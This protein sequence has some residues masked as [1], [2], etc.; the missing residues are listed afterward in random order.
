MPTRVVVVS[1]GL[2]EAQNH[3]LVWA[4]PFA[5]V[6]HAA[7]ERGIDIGGRAEDNRTPPY[8]TRLTP[9]GPDPHFEALVFANRVH[10]PPE[11][12]GHLRSLRPSRAWH[13]V[14]GAVGLFHQFEPVSLVEPGRHAL[15][16]HAERDCVETLDC[17][18]LLRP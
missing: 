12:P 13:E 4:H 5:G 6:D 8:R 10:F 17:R 2:V 18:L 15:G 3:I 7:L 16:V 11:P 1:R 9:E 14:E